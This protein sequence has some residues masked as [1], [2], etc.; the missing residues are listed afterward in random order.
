[1]DSSF[2]ARLDALRERVGHPLIITSAKRCKAHNAR[3]STVSNGP[4]PLGVA[5]DISA[6]SSRERFDIVRAAM[7]VGFT[8]IGIAHSF[9]HV[10]AATRATG[11]EPNLIWF[12]NDR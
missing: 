10:D 5:A 1:M 8:R 4:H 3:V 2:M 12:Y 9:I 7:E 11:H 6:K